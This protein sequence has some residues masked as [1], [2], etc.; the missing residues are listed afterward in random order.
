MHR[1]GAS[2]LGG[3]RNDRQCQPKRAPLRRHSPPSSREAN[4]EEP[5]PRE[6]QAH[7]GLFS[8]ALGQEMHIR[9]VPRTEKL[10]YIQEIVE[11]HG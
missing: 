1:L 8:N 7:L 5:L 2:L 6:D 4:E 11:T 10:A 3:V 9:L